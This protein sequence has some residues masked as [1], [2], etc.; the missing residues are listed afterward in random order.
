M[1]FNFELVKEKYANMCYPEPIE[2]LDNIVVENVITF[3]YPSD[4][5]KHYEPSA[6]D[7]E[8]NL[9]ISLAQAKF[10]EIIKKSYQP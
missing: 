5:I 8:M 10:Y 1:I 6:E 2:E 9:S 7:A 3:W 4:E